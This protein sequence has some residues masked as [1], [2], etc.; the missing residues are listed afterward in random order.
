MPADPGANNTKRRAITCQGGLFCFAKKGSIVPLVPA[1][2]NPTALAILLLGLP[3]AIVA[4]APRCP[5]GTTPAGSPPPGGTAQWCEARPV[6]A[7]SAPSSPPGDTLEAAPGEILG[8]PPSASGRALQGPMT[9]WTHDGRLASHGSYQPGTDGVSSADDLWTFWHDNG[10]IRSRGH[11]LMGM[12]VGCFSFWDE[13]GV[14]HTA[15]YSA[16][17]K[18]F[19]PVLCK[20]PTKAGVDDLEEELQDARTDTVR[21]DMSIG[22]LFSRGGFGIA[23]TSYEVAQPSLSHNVEVSLRRHMR[24][25]RLGALLAAR[26]SDDGGHTGWVAAVILARPLR[27]PHQRVRFD[28]SVALGVQRTDAELVFKGAPEVRGRKPLTF[29]G[30]YGALQF[31][32]ALIAHRHIDIVIAARAEGG[33]P[34]HWETTTI[35]EFPGM[36]PFRHEENWKIGR[37]SLG[38]GLGMR[39][40]FY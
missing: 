30:P 39:V 12:P 36:D 16:E 11:Y 33:V 14:H 37:P 26:T 9:T 40:S 4:C 38:L 32:A 21:F 17:S 13:N 28:V 34:R 5:T 27:S 8:L 3:A 18:S 1:H 29:F 24:Y 2:S 25:L 31:D 7:E 20:G 35:F 15:R 19:E 6:P 10:R 22:T 23:N